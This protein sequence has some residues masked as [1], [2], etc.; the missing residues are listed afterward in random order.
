MS[1]CFAIRGKISQISMPGTLV[2]MG[3]NGP[4][5]SAGASRLHVPGI[6]L[7][8]PADEEQHDAVHVLFAID[9]ALRFQAEKRIQGRQMPQGTGV[10]KSRRRNPSQNSTGRSASR[11]SMSLPSKQGNR[12][13]IVLLTKPVGQFDNRIVKVCLLSRLHRI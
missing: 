11:R 13:S 8:R 5:T 1:A 12:G 2:L 4:R 3:L 10:K 7:A 6:E 9:G